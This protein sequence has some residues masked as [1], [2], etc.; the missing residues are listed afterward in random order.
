VLTA[1]VIVVNAGVNIMQP[2]PTKEEIVQL[3][4]KKLERVPILKKVLK[5]RAGLRGRN[6]RHD[7]APTS[8]W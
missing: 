7:S 3:R 6:P 8:R 1:E 5:G 4:K 2:L